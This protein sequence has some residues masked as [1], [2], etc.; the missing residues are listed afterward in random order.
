MSYVIGVDVGGT[1]TDGVLHDDDGA[2]VAGKAPSTPPD[3]SQGVMDVLAVLAEQ[4]G[5]TVEEMLAKTQ[6]IAHGT[7]SSMNALVTGNVPPVGF[8]TTV[9]H[10]VTR[11]CRSDTRSRWWSGSTVM[12]T[13]S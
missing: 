1:F 6:H 4:I 7:T 9:G 13:W 12:A 8:L 2:V 11:C 3:Y 10:R 5:E